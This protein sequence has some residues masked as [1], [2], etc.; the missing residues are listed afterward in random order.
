M[1]M[2]EAQA[3]AHH[4]NHS[5]E[6]VTDQRDTQAITDFVSICCPVACAMKLA[7]VQIASPTMPVLVTA[8]FCNTGIISKQAM[9]A[10]A[11]KLVSIMWFVWYS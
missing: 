6:F 5:I 10:P 7:A 11:S 9:A 1:C 4:K 3:P 8:P 2:K